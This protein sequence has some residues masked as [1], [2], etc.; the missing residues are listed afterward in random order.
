MTL[1]KL[2]SCFE[3][4]GAH[5]HSHHVALNIRNLSSTLQPTSSLL[6]LV[7]P[8]CIPLRVHAAWKVGGNLIFL[9]QEVKITRNDIGY[10]HR[11]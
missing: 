6:K 10:F 7:K 5:T 4:V 2:S 8:C 9:Y 3:L 1:L 11:Q